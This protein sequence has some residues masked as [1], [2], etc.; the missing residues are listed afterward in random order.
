ML[1]WVGNTT[2]TAVPWVLSVE[3]SGTDLV[4]NVK[5]PAVKSASNCGLPFESLPVNEADKVVNAV[6]PVP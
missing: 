5:L 3:P 1:P 2:S 6:Y 4:L